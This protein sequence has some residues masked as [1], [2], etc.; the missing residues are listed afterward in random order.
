LKIPPHIQRHARQ[1]G[2]LV[3]L[4]A[5]VIP[6]V[7]VL[8]LSASRGGGADIESTLPG[9]G[10]TPAAVELTQKDGGPGGVTVEVTWVTADQLESDMPESAQSLD[11]TEELVFRVKM[12]TDSVD[13][14]QYDLTAI[15]LLRDSEGREFAPQAWEGWEESPHHREGVLVFQRPPSTGG[16]QLT[17]LGLAGTA[18]RIFRWD[19]VP[20]S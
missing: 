17:I 13:L 16:V 11:F 18:Q 1:Y 7:A 12:E 4:A 10:E 15:S 5:A 9:A 6:L 3:V 8:A 19:A 14:S 2:V 20:S